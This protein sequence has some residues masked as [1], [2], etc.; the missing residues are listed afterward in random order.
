MTPTGLQLYQIHRTRF[1]PKRDSSDAGNG[2][3]ASKPRLLHRHFRGNPMTLEIAR[4]ILPK[5]CE[6]PST[7]DVVVP[8][9]KWRVFHTIRGFFDL[10]NPASKEIWAM[11][12]DD[13]LAAFSERDENDGL[14]PLDAVAVPVS[15]PVAELDG[16]KKSAARGE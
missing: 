13:A 2:R 11:D 16:W 5:L 10:A 12:R 1:D 8:V 9:Q 3:P 14:L 7:R 4:V 6:R 15:H